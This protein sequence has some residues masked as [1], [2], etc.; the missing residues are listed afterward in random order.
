MKD[1]VHNHY[2]D[3][4]NDPDFINVKKCD[5]LAN[6]GDAKR[7]VY[8]AE[9]M[10]LDHNEH[11]NCHVNLSL[12]YDTHLAMTVPF[13]NKKHAWAYVESKGKYDARII[14]KQMVLNGWRLTLKQKVA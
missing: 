8:M 13:A 4:L 9:V 5:F 10:G 12:Y 1:K 11:P 6:D 14:H 7:W 2:K 3:I